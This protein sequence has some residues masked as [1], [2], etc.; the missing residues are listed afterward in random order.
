MYATKLEMMEHAGE[1]AQRRKAA[2]D[3]I[4]GGQGGAKHEN[5]FV[6]PIPSD[7]ATAP[8][9]ALSKAD[10]RGAKGVA[11]GNVKRQSSKG[12]AG[13]GKSKG[14][15]ESTKMAALRHVRP[16]EKPK[17]L[18]KWLLELDA[19]GWSKKKTALVRCA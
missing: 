2:R 7:E 14:P 8:A 3:K 12:T 10:A 1:R 19:R 13:G 16:G 18:K 17:G 15:K 9:A 11:K 6:G 5:P 4:L